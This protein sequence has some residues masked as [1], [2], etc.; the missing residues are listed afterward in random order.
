MILGIRLR[1]KRG[2][3]GQKYKLAMRVK[4]LQHVKQVEIDEWSL[5]LRKVSILCN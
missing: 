4:I 5:V 1:I 2:V 3:K